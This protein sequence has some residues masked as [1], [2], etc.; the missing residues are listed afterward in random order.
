MR[1]VLLAVIISLGSCGLE[2]TDASQSQPSDG[3]LGSWRVAVGKTPY[4]YTG[5]LDGT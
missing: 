2:A 5:E 3:D 4:G 1:A